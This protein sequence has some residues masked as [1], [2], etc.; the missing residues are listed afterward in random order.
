MTN[1]STHTQQDLIIAGVGGQGI[2]TISGV[3]G[4]AALEQG[5]HIKQ[6][7]VH[8]M[9]Q[10]GGAVVSHVRLSSRPIASDLVPRGAASLLLAM[11]PME[12][13]RYLAYA[14]PEAVL[15]C[16]NRPVKNQSNYP[17]I[18]AVLARIRGWPR[19]RIV[20]AEA[21]A[22]EAGSPRMA[23]SVMLGAA[24]AFLVLAPEALRA[25]LARW[26]ERKGSEVV[27]KNLAAFDRGRAAAQASGA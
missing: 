4:M 20:D 2:L 9:A 17:D 8:G 26:F 22:R 24:S 12:I 18:E 13:L 14:S 27:E 16:A 6:S 5:L 15:V 19:Q 23:N 1:S 10:R 11:E 25:G 3:I 7:E 21:L